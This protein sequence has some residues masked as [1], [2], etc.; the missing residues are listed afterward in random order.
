MLFHLNNFKN[1]IYIGNNQ[2]VMMMNESVNHT[3]VDGSNEVDLN[4]K[5]FLHI[6]VPILWSIIVLFGI[7][8]NGLVIYI[9]VKRNLYKNSC[10]NCYIINLAI[11]DLS[12]NL[13]CVPVTMTAY[14]S[15]SWILGDFLCSF[16]NLLMFVS[17][18]TIFYSL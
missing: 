5:Y 12:F 7:I 9:I 18:Q 13:V 2:M 8:G 1:I 16:Q 3:L 11:S 10:T 6:I 4:E 14:I 15:Q 17:T